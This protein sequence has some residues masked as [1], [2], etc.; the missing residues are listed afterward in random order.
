VEEYRFFGS[1]GRALLDTASGSLDIALAG[2]SIEVE[3]L[4]EAELELSWRTSAALVAT[5]LGRQEVVVTGELGA[6]VVDLLAGARQSS[7]AAGAAVC[8]RSPSN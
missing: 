1:S 3:P 5:A 2:R 8:V 6:S 7:A 4:T